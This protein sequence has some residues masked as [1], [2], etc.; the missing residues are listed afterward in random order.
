MHYRIAVCDDK[1]EDREY[2]SGMVKHWEREKKNVVSLDLFSSAESFLFQYEEKPDYDIL[3]LDI[4]MDG[5][6]GVSMAKKIRKENE[7]I[8]IIFISGYAD[9]IS[10]GY[11]VAA[12][13]YLV[14]PVKEEKLKEVLDRAVERIKK[15]EKTLLLKN[16][17]EIL[18]IPAYKILYAES[19][20]NYV[21]IHCDTEVKIKMTL[22]QLDELLDARFY[23]VGRSYIVNLTKISRVTKKEI[24]LQNT[25]VIPLPRGAYEGINRAIIDLR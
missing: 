14:K 22:K 4:E 5:M 2:V 7:M 13:H 20:G 8:Q 6:D 23:R 1:E 12:L 21:L 25:Q 18:R 10:E 16:G 17:G 11:E 9:Y 3:L 15:N 19:M 24:R